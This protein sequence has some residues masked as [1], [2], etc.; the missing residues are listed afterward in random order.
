MRTL[1]LLSLTFAACAGAETR[2]L[3]APG[4][5]RGALVMTDEQCRRTLN[6]RRAWGAVGASAAFAG[7]AG[8]IAAAFPPNNDT[9]YVV[10][11]VSLGVGVLGAAAIFV[12]SSLGEQFSQFCT[13]GGAR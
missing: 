10:G 11:G 6:A 1:W 9:R 2:A 12:S 3:V 5:R 4:P 7:G 8:G 13:S